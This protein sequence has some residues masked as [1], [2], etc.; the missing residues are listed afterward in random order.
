M[1]RTLELAMVFALLS[2]AS[3]GSRA[4]QSV[5]VSVV[6]EERVENC[7]PLG[8]MEETANA[9]ADDPQLKDRVVDAL[10]ARAAKLGGNHIVYTA[11]EIEPTHVRIKAEV[12]NCAD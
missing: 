7:D 10:K 1:E 4:A 11:R 6:E 3:C 9:P 12:Y 2:A 5:D 8:S